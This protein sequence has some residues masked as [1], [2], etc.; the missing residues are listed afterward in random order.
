[1]RKTL[2]I[3]GKRVSSRLRSTKICLENIFW[4][5]CVS[6]RSSYCFGLGYG[7]QVAT[8]VKNPP[9]SRRC[10]RLR[11]DPW[12]RMLPWKRKRHPTPAFLP[13]KFHGQRSLA[14]YSQ[15]SCKEAEELNATEQTHSTHTHQRQWQDSARA[16]S[17]RKVL[18][19]V[20]SLSDCIKQNF[21]NTT[22]FSIRAD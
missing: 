17:Y 5:F 2:K 11:L 14:G 3:L 4:G 10:N 9:A 12:A 16:F 22:F 19:M 8:A 20:N 13:G 15:W 1:M 6:P 21:L 7:T 18:K